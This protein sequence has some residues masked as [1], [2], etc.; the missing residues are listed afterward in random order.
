L[1]RYQ[2]IGVSAQFIPTPRFVGVGLYNIPCDVGVS[3][4]STPV[5]WFV[6]VG[7]D[8]IPCDVGVSADPVPVPSIFHTFDASRYVTIYFG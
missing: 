7:F 2:H 3:A 8:Y 4:Q 1:G 6:G 5:P